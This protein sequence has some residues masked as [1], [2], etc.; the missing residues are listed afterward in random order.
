[1]NK[2]LGITLIAISLMAHQALAQ[3]GNASLDQCYDSAVAHSEVLGQSTES[4]VQ[5]QE[6][7]RQSKGALFPVINGVGTY[8]NQAAPS[9][10]AA[11]TQPSEQTTAKITG[12]QPIFHGMKEYALILQQNLNVTAAMS[13]KRQASAVLYSSVATNF[14]SILSLEQV[15]R[16][17]A[18]EIAVDQK[19]IAELNARIRIGRSRITEVLTVKSAVDTLAA[20]AEQ[21]RGQIMAARE[22]FAFNT[23]LPRDTV[24]R[25]TETVPMVP[26]DAL[27]GFIARIDD[28]PDVKA[29]RD[30][31]DSVE[32]N[33]DIARGGHLPTV[34]LTG[35]FYFKR[36]GL[37]QNQNWDVSITGTLPLFAGGVVMSQ[38]RAAVS[39]TRSSELGLALARRAA[40]QDIR[41]N[42]D[43]FSADLA[44]VRKLELATQSAFLNYEAQVKDYRNGLVTNLDVLTSITQWQTSQQT[45][46]TGRYQAKLDYL[47]FQIS[48]ARRPK[49]CGPNNNDP[50]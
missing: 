11:S 21:I 49:G 39:Q 47:K 32:K 36:P 31:L 37:Q 30:T 13:A 44:Q 28:R 46:D 25:E 17:I 33:I 23:L 22:T 3:T 45:L 48:I 26:L 5:A 34:D 24:L 19:Q 6:L 4:V 27:D 29:A 20:Q 7:Y 50:C 8:L 40:D 41:T 38:V 43:N 14:Y 18:N 9:A 15:L 2:H 10:T 1:M 16:D 42:Y 35:D 12:T